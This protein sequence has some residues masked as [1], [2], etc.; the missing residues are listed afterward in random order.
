MI[1][2]T[3]VEYKREG[4]SDYHLVLLDAS[5]NTIIAEVVDPACATGSRFAAGIAKARAE[6]NA[7]LF[8]TRDFQS[9][10]IGVRITGVG[11]FDFL[12]GQ[13]GAAPNGIELHPV[14]D[15]SFDDQGSRPPPRLVPAHR[16]TRIVEH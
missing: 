14:I 9:A 12:H 15:V 1:D 7:S 10:Y 16:D 3:L 6:F 11:M 2:A 5:G 8:A 13:T 4:D